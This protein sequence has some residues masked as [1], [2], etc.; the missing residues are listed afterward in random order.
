MARDESIASKLPDEKNQPSTENHDKQY[1]SKDRQKSVCADKFLKNILLRLRS[2]L[3]EDYMYYQKMIGWCC[4]LACILY[5][6]ELFL[7]QIF[8]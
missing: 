2:I 8:S 1:W 5:V 7:V 6:G 4:L 3:L